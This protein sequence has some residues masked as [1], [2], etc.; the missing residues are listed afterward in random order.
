M[1]VDERLARLRDEVRPEKI[2]DE[3]LDLG[4]GR[5]ED[6]RAEVEDVAVD[7]DRTRMTADPTLALIY[8]PVQ[9]SQLLKHVGGTEA[10]EAGTENHVLTVTHHGQPLL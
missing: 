5:E 7:L 3:S 4:I 6:V 9:L 8:L 1:V 10:G 2:A